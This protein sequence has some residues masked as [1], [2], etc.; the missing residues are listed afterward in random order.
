MMKRLFAILICLTLII[1]TP[2]Y[3]QIDTASL[4]KLFYDGQWHEYNV[5]VT[6]LQVNGEKLETD[7]PPVVFNDR[8]VVPARAVFEKLGA[9]VSWDSA[10]GQVA[11]AMNNSNVLLTINDKYA[12]VN[13]KKHE[14]DIPAK[15]INDRTMVPV[16]FVAETLGMKVDWKA[17]QRLITIDYTTNTG[18]VP[19]PDTGKSGITQDVKISNVDWQVIGNKTR[20][21]ITSN[22]AMNEYSTFELDDHPRLVVDLKNAIL[23]MEKKS[24]D[25]SGN[26]VSKIRYSQYE[27]NP[28]ITRFVIDLNLWTS[29]NVELS[30]DK[31][32]IYVDFNNELSTVKRI[33]STKD[34]VSI[35]MDTVQ[36]PNI[37][38]LSNPDRVIV[39]IPLS[40]L[41]SGEKSIDVNRDIIKTVRYAQFNENTVRIV[42]DVDG[43]PQFEVG[44]EEN[45][46]NLELSTATYKNVHYNNYESPQLILNGSIDASSYK[47]YV[48]GNIYT[49]SIP[50]SKLDLGEGRLFI[51]DSYIDFIDITRNTQTGMADIVFHS[52]KTCK[53]TISTQSS[54]GKTVIDMK[55]ASVS[56]TV[57]TPVNIEVS[58]AI[59]N[60]VV[61][62]D[63][64]HGGK[65]PG[66]IYKD[67]IKEKDPNLTISTYLYKMLKDAGIKAYMTRT[68]DTF[69]ELQDRAVYAN[70]LNA[71]LFISVHNNAMPDP[72]YD[73]TM[74]LY[75]PSSSAYSSEYGITGRRLAQ[76][77]Q[78]EMVKHLGTTDRGLRERPRLVVLNK[79]TMPAIIAEVAFLTNS[80]DREKLKD[81]AF[82]KKAAEALYVATIRALNESVS[83]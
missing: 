51:N 53:Y 42:I 15:I 10:K 60:K 76:I 83:K 57:N 65:D 33:S 70:N 16:R 50:A 24:I 29:Y 79:T 68:D 64:G 34:T 13:G 54:N 66:A 55:E 81:D 21:T 49:L 77:A 6:H 75:Y 78:E 39:D 82:L 41:D 69:V 8:S 61:V 22:A 9:Q 35:K 40:R 28:N 45:E 58:Q 48:E 52:K 30:D 3:A 5:P 27:I 2:V 12:V 4:T 23:D 36:K 74:T 59:K 56:D 17:P 14:M 11:V 38:R 47:E 7:V 18:E 67:E 71:T 26:N 63:A 32:Q 25:I 46:L 72:N 73:G 19:V 37:F 80:S 44:E 1:A 62:I 43:Q 31:K 20:I